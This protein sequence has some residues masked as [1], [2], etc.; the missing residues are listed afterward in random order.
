MSLVSIRREIRHHS[1]TKRARVLKSFFKTGVGQYGYGDKFLGITVPQS[2]AIALKY[3]DLSFDEI[4]ILLKS[5]F[6]EERLIVVL[7]LVHL[8]DVGGLREKK[9]VYDF[10]LKNTKYINNWDLV[11]LSADKIVGAYLLYG[12]RS[13]L[14]K[15]ARSENLWE[16]RIA[17]ISTYQFIRNGEHFETL[18]IAEFLL[19]DTHDLIHKAVG[20]MLREVGKQISQKVEERF[21][22]KH[23]K[24]M[25]RVML[26]YAIERFPK[27]LQFRY[28]NG[29]V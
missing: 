11:D 14:F 6:H 12:S 18:R 24:K 2:R 9:K 20:W 16:R 21:L 23:Y 17:I 1:N 25:P 7:L 13:I 22:K 29:N 5:S 15:L 28:L 26:R 8:F 19:H 10:Y 27:K 3:K 4:A